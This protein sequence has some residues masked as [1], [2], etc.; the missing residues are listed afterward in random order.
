M[1][2]FFVVDWFFSLFWCF[3]CSSFNSFRFTILNRVLILYSFLIHMKPQSHCLS[4][5]FLFLNSLPLY[6]KEQKR[7]PLGSGLNQ[8]PSIL[9]PRAGKQPD[10]S[11]KLMKT[12]TILCCLL[13]A[14]G[15]QS[16]LPLVMEDHFSY[17]ITSVWS[18]GAGDQWWTIFHAM[19]GAVPWAAGVVVYHCPS[20]AGFFGYNFWQIYQ[21]GLLHCILHEIMYW[22][23]YNMMISFETTKILNI[24]AGS[25]VALLCALPSATHI[26]QAK[27]LVVGL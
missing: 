22:L 7:S 11:G 16:R 17:G 14:F 13:L 9:F 5:K 3:S 4:L 6:I 1:W 15:I 2:F 27:P 10:A 26:P 19:D 18:P 8:H 12:T 20:S 24:L 25:C 21:H 23:I